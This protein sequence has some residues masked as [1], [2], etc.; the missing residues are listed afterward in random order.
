MARKT[1]ITE[2]LSLYLDSQLQCRYE[3][4]LKDLD[5]DRNLRSAQK[6][7]EFAFY[8][9]DLPDDDARLA[10]LRLM[11][12]PYGVDRFAATEE[13]SRFVSGIGFDLGTYKTSPDVLLEPARRHPGPP[14]NRGNPR[15]G[16]CTISMIGLVHN[17][18]RPTRVFDLDGHARKLHSVHESSKSSMILVVLS[19]AAWTAQVRVGADLFPPRVRGLDRV[20]PHADLT[21]A[22]LAVFQT[23]SAIG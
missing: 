21:E 8:V 19:S 14:G 23:K 11:Q 1:P 20:R 9:A 7:A 3:M 22:N 6:L 4:A 10:R 17:T 18:P 16:S 2:R 5:P 13:A 12:P 15:R